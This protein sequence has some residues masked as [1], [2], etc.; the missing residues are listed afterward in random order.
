MAEPHPDFDPLV[1]KAMAKW[2]DVP[3]CYGWLSLDRRGQWRLQGEVIS[4]ARAVAF[5]NRHYTSTPEGRWYVQNGP[6]RVFVDLACTPFVCREIAPGRLALHT[7]T[8][9]A[10]LAEVVAL[11]DHDLVLVT[12]HGP[13]VLDDRDLMRFT[14]A[15]GAGPDSGDALLERLLDTSAVAPECLRWYTARPAFRRIAS[16]DLP[17]RYGFVPTPRDPDADRG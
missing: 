15:L 3:D 10:T 9:V 5:L 11:E 12:E 13:A 1:L 7:G 6:Q 2:P 4:H 17:A 8:G 16:A 14:A